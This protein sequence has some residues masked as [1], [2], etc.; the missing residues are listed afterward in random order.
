MIAVMAMSALSMS[1][2]DSKFAAGVNL[3][4]IAG[5]GS[6]TTMGFGLKLQ[7][8]FTENF[9]TELGYT[10]YLNKKFDG[11]WLGDT[12]K[13][14]LWSI[15]LNF[16][17]LFNVSD[18]IKIG[19]MAGIGLN[20]THMNDAA[21][22]VYGDD[23]REAADLLGVAFNGEF[24]NT[25]ALGFQVGV[26]SEYQVSDHFKLGLDLMYKHAQRDPKFADDLSWYKTGFKYNG[27]L[28]SLTAAYCF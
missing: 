19:P 25:M 1:A 6:Y 18:K 24:K 5:T 27:F 21:K 2:Q 10:Y 22:G 12:P 23:A 13:D 4:F 3:D 20:S 8:K 15:N 9:R 17:Y 26:A 14:G 7:Y 16:A 28:A 11:E